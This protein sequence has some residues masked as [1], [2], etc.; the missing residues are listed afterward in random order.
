[1]PDTQVDEVLATS[2][3]ALHDQALRWVKKRRDR[4][5][6]AFAYML[7]GGWGGYAPPVTVDEL[8]R[9]AEAHCPACSMLRRQTSGKNPC[10][11]A[12]GRRTRTPPRV[13]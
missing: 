1:M 9:E 4:H 11:Y 5:T 3:E 6:H 12:S 2:P 7:G 10:P 13:R 8:T